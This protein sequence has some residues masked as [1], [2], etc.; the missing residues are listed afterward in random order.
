MSTPRQAHTEEAAE[1]AEDGRE[2]RPA[3]RPG[4]A[5]FLLAQIGAHAAG[6][7]AERVG[8][9]GLTPPD[10]G[11]LRMIARQPGRSQRSLAE[12]LGVVPSRV[13]TLLDGLDRKGL[14][15]RRRSPEDRRH[16]ALHLSAEGRR[17]LDRVREA[18]TAHENDICGAL[19]R[20]D[21]ERLTELLERIAEQQGLTPGVH[22]GYRLG[23]KSRSDK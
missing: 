19:D 4:G 9:L 18:A 21:R 23:A 1:A 3:A 17:A 16:H 8:E 11:L 22:P 6:R 13:V 10:V 5:A 12:E 7:F 20:K 15:E 2:Q 14:V